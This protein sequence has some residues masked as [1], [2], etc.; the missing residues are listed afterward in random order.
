MI[1]IVIQ[2]KKSKATLKVDNNDI[3]FKYLK[4]LG[5]SLIRGPVSIDEKVAKEID[6][7]I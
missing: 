3:N 5:I 2:Q 6:K 7:K 1:L 4:T